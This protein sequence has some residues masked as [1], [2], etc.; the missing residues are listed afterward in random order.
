VRVLLLALVGVLS[1]LPVWAA[2]EG[3]PAPGTQVI[4]DG[5]I[6]PG[7]RVGPLRL[8]MSLPQLID[9]IGV[10]YKREEFKAEKII[11]YEWRTQ[12]I[13]VSQ[14]L[15]TKSVRVVSAFGANS[16]YRTDR[17]VRLLEPFTKAEG[18][19]GK[20]YKRWEFSE[21]KVILIRYP[22][23]GLQFGLVNDP[24]QALLIGRI[25]QIGIF[26]PGD[27]PPARQP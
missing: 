13:W 16:K 4:G 20:T 26:K 1:A 24:A 15:E 25:F 21:E 17:G 19:Y 5:V 10:V 23:L 27:L 7:Q 22:A 6:V 14:D 2:P 9:T 3:E 12:G 11:L 18:I 8:T